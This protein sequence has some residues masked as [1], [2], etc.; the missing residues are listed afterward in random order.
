MYFSFYFICIFNQN[1]IPSAESSRADSIA[2]TV[3]RKKVPVLPRILCAQMM[4]MM[5][6]GH[7]GPK[8]RNKRS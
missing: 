1:I 8:G 5:G 3:T 6:D 2:E 7:D 4:A